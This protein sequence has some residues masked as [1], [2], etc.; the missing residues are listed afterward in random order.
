MIRMYMY[1]LLE[2]AKA[3]S[4]FAAE[5]N[6]IDV[7]AHIYGHYRNPEHI[8]V[9][10]LPEIIPRLDHEG[11]WNGGIIKAKMTPLL[12]RAAAG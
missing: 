8:I 9:Q 2:G 11:K 3:V 10:E 5:E 6:V 4:G 12:R 1:C 7:Y